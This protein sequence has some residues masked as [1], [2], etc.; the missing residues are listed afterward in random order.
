MNLVSKIIALPNLLMNNNSSVFLASEDYFAS[1]LDA[2]TLFT[3]ILRWV[4]QLFYF[5]AKW[6]MYMIDVIYF[7]LLQ[8]VGITTDTT[9][10]DSSR[11]D[12]TFKLLID[13][14]EEVTRIIKNFLAIAIV[15]IIV[16]AIIAL[17][18]QQ[19]QAFKN[20]KS[21]KNPT[22][23]V[24]KSMLKSVFLLIMTPL[25]AILGIMA[26]SVLLQGLYRATNLSDAKSLSGRIFNA[27]ATMANKYKAYADNGVRIPIKY[28]FSNEDTK[29]EA[30]YYAVQMLGNKSFPSLAYFNENE[31]F[32]GDFIDPVLGGDKIEKKD[33]Y[34]NAVETWVNETYYAYFDRS[35]DY[36][37][38]YFGDRQKIMT[39]HKNEYYAMSDVI[40]Y[41]LDTMAPLYFVTIQELLE[42]AVNADDANNTNL[43]S[44]ADSYKVRLLD[45]EGRVLYEGSYSSMA[46]DIKK[47]N[48][49]YK[50]IQ[51]TSVYDDGEHTY[52]H[53]KDAVD[54]MEGAKFV[55]AY[56]A[57]KS[58]DDYPPSIYGDYILDN[59]VPKEIEKFYFKKDSDSRYQTVDLYYFY[60]E[61]TDKFE[62]D[63]TYD[64]GKT[65]YYKLG[66]DYIKVTDENKGK[67]YYK[68][69]NGDYVPL[70]S[71]GMNFI[72][73]TRA[74]YYMPLASGVSVDGNL[75]FSSS[76]IETGNI[77]TAR[78]IFDDASYPTAIKRLDN[79][80]IMFYRD[81]LEAV[82]EGS[83]SDVGSMEDI[84][85]EEETDES[86][87]DQSFF[88][89]IGSGLKSFGA[90]VKKFVS[91]IFNP[92]KMVPDLTIDEDKVATQYTNKT[93]SVAEIEDGKLYISY[94]FADSLTS[95]L[96]LNQYTLKL[97][98]LFEPL[99]INYIVLLVGSV[100]LFRI[101]FNAIFGVINKAISLFILFLIYPVA[102]STIPLDETGGALKT[103]SYAKWSDR[104]TKLV[105]STFGLMLGI[106]FVFVII[107]V[108]DE[109]NFFTPEHFQNSKAL[110]RIAVVLTNPGKGL[111]S[112]IL[113]FGTGKTTLVA[114]DYDMMSSCVNK[115]LRIIFQIAGFSL[116]IG[117]SGKKV[118][119]KENFYSVIQGVVKPGGE[120]VLDGSPVESVKKTLKSVKNVM[121]MMANPFY[122]LKM[123]KNVAKKGVDIAKD[124]GGTALDMVPGSQIIRDGGKRIAEMTVI[125]QQD[126][127]R[128][129]LI[130]ALQ[131]GA[132]KSEVEEKL[133]AFQDSHKQ[134]KK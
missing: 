2:D 56:K 38:N 23:D 27:S 109:I 124:I 126:A 51:Y 122:Q 132:E 89:K 77:I 129:A 25:I 107:P 65:Y 53:I 133:K 13:N 72:N 28:H 39:T 54:E 50:Y 60:N 52:V 57:E 49:S 15:L 123:A 67:F 121:E 85:A 30:T 41:A 31:S 114:P 40:G 125:G 21:K 118:A 81:D 113:G 61:H 95:S 105:F 130:Q 84:E 88:Q 6:L 119:G 62:K 26:S 92:L 131:G 78:G 63:K 111:V 37:A 4:V 71:F 22:S 19:S 91:S 12:P 102:C 117:S 34:G 83:V 93:H 32:S 94:F 9:I 87:E 11:T 48:P 90:S 86:E 45:G 3:R 16:T 42:S 7:Y 101:I 24:M 68:F 120:G 58:T 82:T 66:E 96:N 35:E 75:K 116:I 18:K 36:N 79:G 69:K 106:N 64:A 5:I 115:I 104:F 134:G 103:G 110:E 100:V 80:N 17:I 20:A 76:Y 46:S 127:T 97:S 70:T 14:K 55:I 8:L 108:V 98:S 10:F 29:N 128:K 59:G 73:I 33:G 74:E 43:K 99:H 1:M 112:G 47:S 44:L